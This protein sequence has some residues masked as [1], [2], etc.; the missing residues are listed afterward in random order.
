LPKQPRCA[1]LDVHIGSRLRQRRVALHLTQHRLADLIGVAYQQIHKYEHGRDRISASTLWDLS[2]VLDVS[3]DYFFEGLRQS[4]PSLPTLDVREV[5]GETYFLVRA[6]D[7]I[8]DP[9]LK[10]AVWRAIRAIAQ[11]D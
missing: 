9:M 5:D 7:R 10:R 2:F 8:R 6:Y 4:S 3:V 11:L 1:P